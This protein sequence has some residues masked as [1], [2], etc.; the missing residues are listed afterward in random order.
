MWVE[1]EAEGEGEGKGEGEGEVE[2]EVVVEVEVDKG[3]CAACR[4]VALT[5]WPRYLPR[6]PPG[7]QDPYRPGVLCRWTWP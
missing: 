6:S 1:G 5:A 3:V 4:V 7:P 2:V